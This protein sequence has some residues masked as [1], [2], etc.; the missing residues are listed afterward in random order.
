MEGESGQAVED[1]IQLPRKPR[2]EDCKFKASLG[3]LLSLCLQMKSK[4]RAGDMCPV[5]VGP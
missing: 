3:N 4:K 1:I 5:Y 2:Q